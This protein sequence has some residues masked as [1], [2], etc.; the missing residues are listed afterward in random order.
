M[1]KTKSMET[2]SLS[3]YLAQAGLAS[4]RKATELINQGHVKVNGAIMKEP[5]YKVQAGDVITCDDKPIR[6][7]EKIYILLNKPKNYITTVSDEKGRKTVMDLISDAIGVR[8]YPVG[9]LD[10]NT[11]GLLLL[12]NDG[13]LAQKLSHPKYEVQKTY[14]VTLNAL[15]APKD[16]AAVKEGLLLDDGPVRVDAISYVHGMPRNQVKVVLHSGKNRIVRRIFEF[17]GYEVT[18]LDRIGYAHL[19]KKGLR[20]GEWRY[21]TDD[22]LRVKK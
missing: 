18:K 14:M 15:F 3:K 8:V 20:I 12:T 1:K 13:D 21:L 10:R 11:T 9:R 19:T 22:E 2:N 16:M 6:V 4:R 5:G 17:F 7:Q